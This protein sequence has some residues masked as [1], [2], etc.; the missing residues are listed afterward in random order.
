MKSPVYA[1]LA[2]LLGVNVS[3]AG[4]SVIESLKTSVSPS[5]LSG[6]VFPDASKSPAAANYGFEGAPA[7][8]IDGGNIRCAQARA[9]EFLSRLED[10]NAGDDL[11]T[12]ARLVCHFSNEPTATVKYPDGRIAYVGSEYSDK[13]SWKY[14]NGSYAF[15][16]EGYSDKG[17]WKYPN[18]SYALVGEGWSDKGSWKYPSGKYA[19][20]GEGWSDKG[21]WKYPNGSYAFVGEGYSDK[22]SWKYPNGKYAFVGEGYSDKGS[23]KYPNGKYAFAGPGF[24]NS[25]SWYYPNGTLF[26]SG[27]G[28]EGVHMLTQLVEDAFNVE[29]PY[30]TGLRDALDG[31][32]TM[33]RLQWIE[34]TMPN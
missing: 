23:W 12:L 17:S 10:P 6:K 11:S 7:R 34:Q 1:A 22:G 14:P 4:E 9:A 13:G 27:G 25:G 15:V 30:R 19:L 28:G 31:V 2:V 5:V 3:Y 24:G 21:S 29:F 18:G 16:G 26:T 33:F 8:N 20:V 32:N